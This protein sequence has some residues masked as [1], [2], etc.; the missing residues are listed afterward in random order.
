MNP[1][2]SS[3]IAI[4]DAAQLLMKNFGTKKSSAM[5]ER[6][7]RNQV[8]IDVIKDQ[9]DASVSVETVSSELNTPNTNE[10]S[11]I[12]YESLLPPYNKD[13]TNIKDSYPFDL[14]IESAVLYKIAEETSSVLE[15]V[16]GSGYD[17]L[18]LYYLVTI[19]I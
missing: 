1:L 9:L 3:Q 6:R 14:I 12:R 10:D 19:I 16:D 5:F 11:V 13:A 4:P 18:Y 7:K 2:E 15:N 8:N 17:E